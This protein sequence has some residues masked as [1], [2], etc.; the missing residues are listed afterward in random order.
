MPEPVRLEMQRWGRTK[1]EFTDNDHWPWKLYV[2]EARRM[3]SDYVDEA[4]QLWR[5]RGFFTSSKPFPVSYRALRPRAA[6][7]V[8]LL[9]P[10]CVSASHAAF[11]SVRMEPVF[12]ML[13]HAAGTAAGLAVERNGTVQAL[14]YAALRERLL[15]ERQILRLYSA[16]TVRE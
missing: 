16:E 9:V 2:R 6:E 14:P 10:C 5:E 8:N 12:M 7:C 15:E 13:G 4:G 3:I 11:G 1:D